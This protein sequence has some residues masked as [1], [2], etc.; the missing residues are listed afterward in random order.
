MTDAE[1]NKKWPYR[2]RYTT[3]YGESGSSCTTAEEA[4]KIARRVVNGFLR[5]ARQTDGQQ[6]LKV[7]VYQMT[8]SF[9][10]D[11]I[12]RYR[13]SKDCGWE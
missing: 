6:T 9:G 12:A 11:V 8:E 4:K 1:Y 2:V 7:M 10:F 13:V 3:A 5:G